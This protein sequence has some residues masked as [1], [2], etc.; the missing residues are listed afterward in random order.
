MSKKKKEERESIKINDISPIKHMR[1]TIT[2]KDFDLTKGIKD[3][4]MADIEKIGKLVPETADTRV[5]L[6]AKRNRLD[7]QRAEITVKYG[8]TIVRAEVSCDDM[9]KSIADASETVVK[10]IKK[11]KDKE[12]KKAKAG[13]ETIR[14]LESEMCRLKRR[15]TIEPDMMTCEE[16]CDQMELLGHDFYLF[17]NTDEDGKL[18]AVYLRDDGFG[19]LVLAETAE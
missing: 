19:V 17:K 7:S 3:A 4:V 13:N 9:Y 15:K 18:S 8:K 2:G 10:R 14:N 16:A 1:I 5:V 11:F 6:S 12:R